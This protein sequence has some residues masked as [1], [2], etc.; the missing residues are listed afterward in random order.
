MPYLYIRKVTTCSG[1]GA[2]EGG[3]E[4]ESVWIRVHAWACRCAGAS[5]CLFVVS[6]RIPV[7]LKSNKSRQPPKLCFWQTRTW[8]GALA[9]G[10][11]GCASAAVN[12]TFSITIV[13]ILRIFTIRQRDHRKSVSTHIP[14]HHVSHVLLQLPSVVESP[15]KSSV[16]TKETDGQLNPSRDSAT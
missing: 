7:N 16:S 3:R 12:H 5:P 15:V 11:Q 10:L 2:S 8:Q 1:E 9:E 14:A 13:H 4:R 6:A